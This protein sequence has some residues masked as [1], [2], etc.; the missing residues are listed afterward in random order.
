MKLSLLV[1]YITLFAM[2]A[3][4]GQ[5]PLQNGVWQSL[6]NEKDLAGWQTYL[7]SPYAKEGQPKS[8]A[9]GLEQ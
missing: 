2:P 5:K 6:F 7:D 3:V 8:S 9:L 4:F 1:T